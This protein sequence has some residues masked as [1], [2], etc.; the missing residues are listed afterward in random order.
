MIA[1]CYKSNMN[2]TSLSTLYTQLLLLLC[3]HST[4]VHRAMENFSPFESF[5]HKLSLSHTPRTN[6][7]SWTF[8]CVYILLPDW[9]TFRFKKNTNNSWHLKNVPWSSIEFWIICCL[10]RVHECAERVLCCVYFAVCWVKRYQLHTETQPSVSFRFLHFIVAFYSLSEWNKWRIVCAIKSMYC[11]CQEREKFQN[12]DIYMRW[13]KSHRKRQANHISYHIHIAINA[14]SRTY[15][16][17][18]LLFIV[19][20]VVV[21]APLCLFLRVRVYVVHVCTRLL[22]ICLSLIGLFICCCPLLNTTQHTNTALKICSIRNHA[23]LVCYFSVDNNIS[24]FINNNTTNNIH[25]KHLIRCV[26]HAL[27]W[28]VFHIRT[29]YKHDSGNRLTEPESDSNQAHFPFYHSF[30]LACVCVWVFWVWYGRAIMYVLPFEYVAWLVVLLL[31]TLL[32]N[33]CARRVSMMQLWRNRAKKGSKKE[34]GGRYAEPVKEQTNK[35][36]SEREP[37]NMIWTMAKVD[38]TSRYVCVWLRVHVSLRYWWWIVQH[39]SV[40]SMHAWLKS[41]NSTC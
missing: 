8:R 22:Y 14:I 12:F 5:A 13:I 26:F 20:V 2:F 33:F 37:N 23:C 36:A 15:R 24:T 40:Q 16:H 41:W 7:S 18:M 3:I 31:S 17:D 29:I 4:Q 19:V 35:R 25:N 1:I 11:G 6:T 10:P 9:L 39:Q 27:L 21:C 38:C 30:A 28:F 32:D 34:K